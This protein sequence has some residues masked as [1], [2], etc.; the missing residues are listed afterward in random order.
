MTKEGLVI[1]SL[2]SDVW[3]YFNFYAYIG[4]NEPNH[5]GMFSTLIDWLLEAEEKDQAVWIVQHVNIGGSTDYESLPAPS[6]LYYQIMDRFNQTI[7]GNFFGHTHEDEFGVFYNNNATVKSADT[8]VGVGYIMPSVTTYQDLNA[9]FRYYLVD[10]ETFQ[11]LDSITYYANV[12]ETQEWTRTGVVNWQLEYSAKDTYDYN[13][14]LGKHE[15][16]TPAFWH[17]VAEDIAN[18]ATTFQ[19]YTDLRTKKF[20]PYAPVTGAARNDTICGLTSMSV[21]IFEDC[22]A[23]MESTT[24]FL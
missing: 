11:I 10:P 22:L 19:T 5:T 4:A 9:G 23:S 2:N 17:T 3:Y 8:A 20:R 13:G 18:N 24:S 21:P 12:S 7:R 1:I 14:T 16:L 6:D 15:P